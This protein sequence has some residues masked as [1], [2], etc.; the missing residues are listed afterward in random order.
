LAACAAVVLAV[1]YPLHHGNAWY[2]FDGAAHE[3]FGGDGAGLGLFHA[4]P[5]FQFGPL[6]VLVAAPFAYLPDSVAVLA[7]AA[8][9]M[10]LGVLALL[11][12]ERLVTRLH[13][14]VD[15]QRL[16]FTLLCGAVPLLVA[17][18]DIA[19]RTTHI[20]DTVA[21]AAIAGAAALLAQRRT[22]GATLVLA[23]G[24][25][26]KPW[27]LL[28]APMLAGPP[29]RHRWLRPVAAAA[30]GATTWLPFLLNEPRTLAS[31]ADFRIR[32]S[33]T[34][35]LRML[36]VEVADTPS[37]ARPAQL[38]TGVVLAVVLVRA[39]RWWAVPMGAIAV[40]LL[41]DPGTHHYYAAGLGLGVLMWELVRRPTDVPW[42]TIA[43]L[44]LL[45]LTAETTPLGG[46]AG[47]VRLLGLLAILLAVVTATGASRRRVGVG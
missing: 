1:R 26:V 22:T 37:W 38:V 20:D 47:P 10:A 28:C 31:L 41:L 27:A 3:L 36:G 23:L 33:A 44:V 5:E 7:A 46:A 43:V 30:L 4:H 9:G 15:R 17:W 45:E 32:N 11:A 18:S 14:A 16:Q 25:A 35:S 34:S 21:L 19:V 2:F 6:A 29:G 24:M 8:C 40:R 39:G 12:A 13:P 42:A